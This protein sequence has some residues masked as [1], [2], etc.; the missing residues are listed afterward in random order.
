M[1]LLLA[2]AGPEREGELPSHALAVVEFDDGQRASLLVEL[3]LPGQPLLVRGAEG[4]VVFEEG[5]ANA[6]DPAS[7]DPVHAVEALG[8]GEGFHLEQVEDRVELRLPLSEEPVVLAHD[9]RSL[10]AAELLHGVSDPGP[11]RRVAPLE[12][13]NRPARID[14]SLDEWDGRALAVQ[15]AADVQSGEASWKGPRDASFGVAARLH[16]ER[17]SLGVR[18]RDDELR[19]GE[20]RLELVVPGQGTVAIAMQEAGSCEVPEGWEC[21]F[22][23]SVDFGTG[24][25]LSF[26]DEREQRSQQLGVVVRYVDQDGQEPSTVLASAPSAELVARYQRPGPSG[27][28]AKSRMATSTTP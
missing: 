26:P 12:A 27:S 3:D 13:A 16:H 2:C 1:L 7:L 22:V 21:A 28:G 5:H 14:G 8:P 11:F 17:V 4:V 15:S 9:V 25:E 20:D 24:L 19:L 23:P 10:L 18:I 6:L